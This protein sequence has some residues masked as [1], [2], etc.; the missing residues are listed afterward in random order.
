MTIGTV[1]GMIAAV[2]F[3]ILVLLMA[4]PLIKL[5]GLI[6]ELRKSVKDVTVDART[7]VNEA[8]KTVAGVNAQLD[9]VDDVTRGAAQVA[10]DMSAV[11]TL[12]ASSVG[13]PL[14]KLAAFSVAAQKMWQERK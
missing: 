9:R 3:A 1:A 11:S 7:T 2:A 4:I 5:G 13:R 10:Q 14:I 12:V 8:T 6:D